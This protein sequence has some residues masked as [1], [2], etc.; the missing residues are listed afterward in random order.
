MILW[1]LGGTLA[2]VR[3]VF[4]DPKMD[5]RW[6]MFGA[7]LPDLIDKPLGSVFLV[8][9]FHSD[10]LFAHALIFPVTLMAVVVI[11]TPRSSPWRQRLVS[12][13]IGALF[14]IVLDGAW[15]PPEAFWWPFFGFD[16]PERVDPGL[17]DL[18]GRMVTDWR[19]WVGEALG[20]AYLVYLW[21]VR[22]GGELRH[23]WRTGLIPF[24]QR[25]SPSARS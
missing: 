10:R 12:L 13:V 24:A 23:F 7:L 5:L 1:H 21:R 15:N 8:D 2:M 17:A 16:F 14:H 6:P 22:L 18:F 3:A 25:P 4:R 11:L 9:V 20:L 19:I